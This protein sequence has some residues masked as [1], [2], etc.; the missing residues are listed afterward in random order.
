MEKLA[1]FK[2]SHHASDGNL[3]RACK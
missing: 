1:S 3:G 2:G